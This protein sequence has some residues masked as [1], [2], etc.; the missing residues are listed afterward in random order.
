MLIVVLNTLQAKYNMY[1]S[2]IQSLETWMFSPTK[3]FKIK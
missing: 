1:V 3:N 2:R